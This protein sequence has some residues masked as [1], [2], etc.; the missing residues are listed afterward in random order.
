MSK[1]LINQALALFDSSE[2][3]NSFVEMANHKE[4]MKMQYLQKAKNPLLKYLVI[5]KHLALD[6]S[7]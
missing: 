3:W 5:I 7:C 6:F 2:K 1:E 4:A